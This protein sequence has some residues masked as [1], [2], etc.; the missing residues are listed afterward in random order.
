MYELG[1]Y[2]DTFKEKGNTLGIASFLNASDNR[3]VQLRSRRVAKGLRNALPMLIG[4]TNNE[5]VGGAYYRGPAS[6]PLAYARYSFDPGLPHGYRHIIGVRGD[7]DHRKQEGIIGYAISLDWGERARRLQPTHFTYEA[8]TFS[9]TTPEFR[10]ELEVDLGSSTDGAATV[11]LRSASHWLEIVPGSEHESQQP[12]SVAEYAI[13]RALEAIEE[14]AS[15]GRIPAPR[16]EQN[17]FR[18]GSLRRHFEIVNPR[19]T[20]R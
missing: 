14:S 4:S 18:S 11:E 9:D 13:Y 7:P 3:V 19:P 15:F 5:A 8:V 17:P 12:Q 10:T 16:I 6:S 1:K 2:P 20:S